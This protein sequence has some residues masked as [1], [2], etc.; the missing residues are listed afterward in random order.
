MRP[1]AGGGTVAVAVPVA[2]AEQDQKAAEMQKMQPE[3]AEMVAGRR[4]RAG[5]LEGR[6]ANKNK[7]AEN[8]SMT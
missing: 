5:R 1:P 7:T 6:P 3:E 8:F 2:V 4:R